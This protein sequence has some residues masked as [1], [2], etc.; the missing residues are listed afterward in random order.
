MDEEVG[1]SS[2]L[3]IQKGEVRSREWG[4]GWRC[5]SGGRTSY[6]GGNPGDVGWVRGLGETLPVE[7][8]CAVEEFKV[9]RSYNLTVNL[10]IGGDLHCHD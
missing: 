7:T 9:E 5:F 6:T 10:T 4:R 2:N 1:N 3:L 8:A